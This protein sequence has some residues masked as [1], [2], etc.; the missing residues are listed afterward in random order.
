[1][2]NQSKIQLLDFDFLADLLKWWEIK[3]MPFS[4]QKFLKSQEF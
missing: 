3:G 4:N 2:Q 1:M